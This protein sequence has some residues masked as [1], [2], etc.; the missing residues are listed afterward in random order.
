MS[1]H[2]KAA[3]FLCYRQERFV[4]EALRAM[5][6][7]AESL[8]VWLLDDASPDAT[9]HVVNSCLQAMPLQGATHSIEALPASVNGGL[10]RNWN[11]VIPLLRE[12]WIYVFE[13][14]DV[15]MPDRVADSARFAAAH[16]SM[17]VFACR[18]IEN[19]AAGTSEV[20]ARGSGGVFTA[21]AILAK[22]FPE[23]PGCSLVLRRDIFTQFGRL[24]WRL[25][26]VDFVLIRR[27]F[28]LGDVGLLE[29]AL[30]SYR[31]HDANVSRVFVI[32]FD[33]LQGFQQS[34]VKIQR[35]TL[36]TLH[37]AGKLWRFAQRHCAAGSARWHIA[38]GIYREA[39]AH[40]ALGLASR[41]GS[42]IALFTA[43]LENLV[44]RREHRLS[45]W[46]L[47]LA[48]WSGAWSGWQ[49]VK[50]RLRAA[51]RPA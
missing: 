33:S 29:Q 28:M 13:G 40:T 8:H 38:R 25:M 15:S 35:H 12:Q 31:K 14:D 1:E 26:T 48:L 19:S 37:E 44:H 47:V 34:M 39:R 36:G 10:A 6:A 51:L 3:V 24:N 45:K 46:A 4:E 43:A 41:R 22:G 50:R 27:G 2:D 17:A 7:Q 16:P 11:R 32:R 49:N 18:V 42:R 5:L 30:V 21:D 9:W 20:P 23:L